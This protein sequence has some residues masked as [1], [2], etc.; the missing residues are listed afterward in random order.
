M[1]TMTPRAPARKG[2]TV[3]SALRPDTLSRPA[4]PPAIPLRALLPGAP[5]TLTIAG[6]G[7]LAFAL[8]LASAE[9]A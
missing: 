8:A 9:A 2:R 3:T 7:A 5:S 1:Q 4:A 6:P